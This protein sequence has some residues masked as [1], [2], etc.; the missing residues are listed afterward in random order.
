MGR[1][2]EIYF[3]DLSKEKQDEILE[4]LGENGNYDVFPIATINEP[5]DSDEEQ[6]GD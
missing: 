4:L 1:S 2:V 3:Q 6:G 5:E